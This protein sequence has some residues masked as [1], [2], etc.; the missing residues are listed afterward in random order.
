M[1]QLLKQLLR[2]DVTPSNSF[3]SKVFPRNLLLTF[4]S[5]YFGFDMLYIISSWSLFFQVS[6]ISDFL[7]D[8][9]Y[10]CTDYRVIEQW[11]KAAF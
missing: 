11:E 1:K 7:K 8:Y 2:R 10:I 5:L 3:F 6:N 9:S 4:T